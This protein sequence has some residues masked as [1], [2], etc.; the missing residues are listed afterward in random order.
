LQTRIYSF[1]FHNTLGIPWLAGRLLLLTKDSS[2]QF[3]NCLFFSCLCARGQHCADWSLFLRT[4]KGALQS[5]R[6]GLFC[7]W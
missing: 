2:V 4:V 1:S 3:I 5:W 7:S 6:C